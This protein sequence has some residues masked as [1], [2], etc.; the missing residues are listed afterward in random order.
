MRAAKS[1]V[2]Q[3]TITLKN[4]QKGEICSILSITASCFYPNSELKIKHCHNYDIVIPQIKS[5]LKSKLVLCELSL[6]NWIFQ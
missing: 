5:Y 6:K 4:V 1:K 3:L 2:L